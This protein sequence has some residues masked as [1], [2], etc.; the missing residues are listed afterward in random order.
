MQPYRYTNEKRMGMVSVIFNLCTMVLVLFLAHS[1]KKTLLNNNINTKLV[2]FLLLISVSVNI[3][4]RDT[5]YSDTMVYTKVFSEMRYIGFMDAFQYFGGEKLFNII[6]WT[7]AQF[8]ENV[9]I[10]LLIIWVLFAI[11]FIKSLYKL[12]LPWQVAVVFFTYVN[13]PFFIYYTQNTIRQGVAIALLL[14]AITLWLKG[15]KGK[16]YYTILVI[17]PFLH[18]M[19]TPFSMLLLF[20]SKINLK[21]RMFIGIWT[22]LAAAFVTNTNKLLILPIW[23]L[24]PNIDAYTGSWAMS[25]Y[26]NKVNRIDFLVF[27]G[28]WIVVSTLFYQFVYRN[29]TYIKLIKI[30][31]MFNS[32][33][34]LLGFVAYSDRIAINSWFLI[35]ILVWYP[36]FK[37]N[38]PLTIL[39]YVV[40]IVSFVT[41][42]ITGVLG[43]Y[44]PFD[45]FNHLS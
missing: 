35:P 45:Y 20:A 38:R 15:E 1:N 30:Y 23:N 19:C 39:K 14:Y 12:F 31:V 18:W 11:P 17:T 44:N 16:T 34:L 43:D 5:D 4:F 22:I 6:V 2:F 26:G 24:I 9:Y 25:E 41:G 37:S 3:A 40:I 36:I 10:F 32:L 8:T 33:F 13:F 29:D 7:T 27:S 21:L 28:F 42:Y